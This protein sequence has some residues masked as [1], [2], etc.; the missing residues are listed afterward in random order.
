M[1]MDVKL[2][3]S[4][5]I[6]PEFNYSK[7]VKCREWTINGDRG[8]MK[9]PVKFLKVFA[10]AVEANT[11]DWFKAPVLVV[12]YGTTVQDISIKSYLG[13]PTS[14]TASVEGEVQAWLAYIDI[15]TWLADLC[16]LEIGS[17]RGQYEFQTCPGFEGKV[18]KYSMHWS[19]KSPNM[20]DF[21]FDFAVGF[22]V[23]WF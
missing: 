1:V 19:A 22:E 9:F 12:D 11:G 6:R 15:G 21:D 4:D 13:D 8:I 7:T 10:D 23:D 3:I 16:Y 20:I 2:S 18:G 17:L 5:D 14:D